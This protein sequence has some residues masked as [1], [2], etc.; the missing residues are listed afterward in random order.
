MNNTYRTDFKK[1]RIPTLHNVHNG[2]THKQEVHQEKMAAD[3][4][5]SAY[6]DI[7]PRNYSILPI[8]K[9][10]LHDIQLLEERHE[11]AFDCFWTMERK[12]AEKNGTIKLYDA[13]FKFYSLMDCLTDAEQSIVYDKAE[14][15]CKQRM[16]SLNIIQKIVENPNFLEMIL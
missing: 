9:C 15:Y 6:Y 2:I 16:S 13:T 5:R 8:E 12:K 7:L 1:M 3:M 11:K 14:A 10:S 4:Q